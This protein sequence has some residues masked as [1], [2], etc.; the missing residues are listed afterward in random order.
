MMTDNEL[1]QIIDKESLW[2]VRAGM[3]SALCKTL[4]EALKQAYQM[5]AQGSSPSRIVQMPD[6]AV[7]ID[8]DQIYRL[9]QSIGLDCA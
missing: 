4:R 6:D 3:T 7:V 1:L 8:A 2:M 9:W 5:S